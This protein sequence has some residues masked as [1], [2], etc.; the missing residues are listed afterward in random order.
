MTEPMTELLSEDFTESKK[1][2]I[3]NLP[4]IEKNIDQIIFWSV[5]PSGDYDKDCRTG[6]EYGAL[7]LEHMIE[8]DFSPF[9]TWCVMDMP[10]KKYC[11]G[12]E[13]GFLEF[14]SEIAVSNTSNNIVSQMLNCS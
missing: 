8:A 10:R 4:F 13:V 5:K 9:L 2:D 1:T 11:S 3:P 6:R 7:A 14:F 12:I